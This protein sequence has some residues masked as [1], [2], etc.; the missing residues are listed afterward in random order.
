ME[1]KRIIDIPI[2]GMSEK[3]FKGDY[4][5]FCMRFFQEYHDRAD[6]L[7]S[8]YEEL[9]PGENC[10]KYNEIVGYFSVSLTSSD[11]WIDL[12]LTDTK[13]IVSR[14][15][16]KHFIRNQYINGAHFRCKGMDNKTIKEG[17]IEHIKAASKRTLPKS[18][19]IDFEIFENTIDYFDIKQLM[20]DMV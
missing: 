11:I 16:Q 12:Y 15:P 19:F 4:E 5:K 1:R 20:E 17:I 14:S 2:Y 9:H 18:R 3:K 7:I 10:W 6:E 13:R 8:V